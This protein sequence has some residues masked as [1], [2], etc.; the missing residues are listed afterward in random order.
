MP[1]SGFVII[2]L[3]HPV[4]GHTATEDVQHIPGSV[5]RMHPSEQCG[6]GRVLQ[7]PCEGCNPRV[8]YFELEKA[9]NLFFK[10]TCV[11]GLC[12]LCFWP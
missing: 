11:T 12:H 2:S 3:H 1:N 5:R 10:N 4:L 9:L 8:V 7:G 6:G